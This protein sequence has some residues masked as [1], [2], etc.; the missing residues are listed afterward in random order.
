M[1]LIE[2]I[3]TFLRPLILGLRLTANIIGGHLLT[4]LVWDILSGSYS[5]HFS[6]HFLRLYERFVCIIQRVIFSLLALDYYSESNN[7]I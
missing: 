1:A 3:R 2:L 4:E 7:S 5:I 6:L